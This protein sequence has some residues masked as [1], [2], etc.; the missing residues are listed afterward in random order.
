MRGAT[1]RRGVV[2]AA[3]GE[4]LTLVFDIGAAFVDIGEQSLG[5]VTSDEVGE[6]MQPFA[7]QVDLRG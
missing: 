4:G 5:V 6:L 1:T 7:Y 3:I 2:P